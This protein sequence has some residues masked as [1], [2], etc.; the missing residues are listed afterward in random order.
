MMHGEYDAWCVGCMVSMI[1][2][3]G[4]W[5]KGSAGRVVQEEQCRKSSA[6]RVVQ[7]E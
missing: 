3:E 6:G 7:E 4:Q 1:V 5:R 2:E